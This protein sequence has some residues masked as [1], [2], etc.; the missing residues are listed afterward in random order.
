MI[1][2]TM[3]LFA[4]TPPPQA[5]EPLLMGVCAQIARAL[6][7]PVNHVRIVV[8]LAVAASLVI[9]GLLVYGALG[10][11]FRSRTRFAKS[12]PCNPSLARANSVLDAYIESTRR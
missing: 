6:R 11:T 1:M 3:P 12:R 10:L 9:P 7:L 8:A 2:A 5:S 4:Y